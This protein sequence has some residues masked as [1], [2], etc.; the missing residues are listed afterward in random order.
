VIH[1][2]AEEDGVGRADAALEL[3][4]GLPLLGVGVE[5]RQVDGSQAQ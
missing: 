2:R 5:R 4:D 3:A 1:R